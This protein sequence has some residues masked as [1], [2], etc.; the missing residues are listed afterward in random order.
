MCAPIWVKS[1]TGGKAN[2]LNFLNF[3]CLFMD[4]EVDQ[5]FMFGCM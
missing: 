2:G 5:V 3:V 4:D 1:T